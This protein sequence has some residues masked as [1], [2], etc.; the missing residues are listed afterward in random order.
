MFEI[1]PLRYFLSAYE[2]GSISRAAQVNNVSQPSVS[3]AIQRLERDLGGAL[4]LRSRQGLQVTALGTQLYRE[5]AASV[6][7]LADLPARLRPRV[8]QAVRIYCHPDMVLAPFAAPLQALTRR[9]PE[10][11]PEFTDD[12]G[13]CDIACI[14]EPCTPAGYVF[15]PLWEDSYG[16]ALPVGHRLA[17]RETVA[18]ADL[19]G[20]PFIQRPYCPQADMLHLLAEEGLA[21]G[22][23]GAAATND[24]QLLDLVAAGLGVAFVPLRHGAQHAGVCV[25]PVRPGPQVRRRAGLAHRRTVAARELAEEIA[26][27]LREI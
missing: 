4:F 19:A 25:R 3:A 23:A 6:S 18:L 15:L 5:A 21:P 16:V 7:H 13:S 9:R 27:P 12:P 17:Q 20:A 1:T 8:P 26:A 24:P 22:R 14:A 2:T 11:M 10:V